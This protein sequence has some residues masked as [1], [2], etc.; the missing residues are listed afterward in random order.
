DRLEGFVSRHGPA[1]YRLP[2]N[3]DTIT[4]LREA[5]PLSLPA[6]IETGAGPVVLFDPGFPLHWRVAD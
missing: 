2:V 6:T 5:T 1:F 4:L 3:D